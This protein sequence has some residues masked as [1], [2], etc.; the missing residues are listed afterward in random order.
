MKKLMMA[1]VVAAALSA[2]A[3]M[4]V[5]VI[6]M[7]TLV[8]NHPSY[9]SNKTLLM[10]T[11][12]DYQKKLEAMKDDLDKIQEEGKQLTEQ[13]KN[14]MLAANAKQKLE[15]DLIE[16]QNKFLAGQQKMRNEAMRSQQDLR[17][18]EARLMKT[19]GDDLRKRVS[20]VA[21]EKGFDMILDGSAVPYFKE[22]LDVTDEIL[23]AM[24]VDPAT[25]K[26]DADESK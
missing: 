2:S 20:T 16:V 12:K 10:T 6:D 23:K 26:K 4:K 8:R 13:A 11:E 7:L 17:D 24:G 18:L 9:E 14:P 15:K 1:V 25:I 19:T 22:A 3:E 21:K 5:G